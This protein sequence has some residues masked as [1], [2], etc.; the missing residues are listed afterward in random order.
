[1]NAGRTGAP[2]ANSLSAGRG[3]AAE[4][5]EVA[6]SSGRTAVPEAGGVELPVFRYHPDPLRTGSVEPSGAACAACGKTRGFLYCEPVLWES[7]PEG[8]VCPWCIASGKAHAKFGG[9]FIDP[10]AIGGFGRWD[11]VPPDVI[12]EIAYRTPGFSGW[13]E[14]RW[15]S[16]C[17]DAAEF[18]GPGGRAEVEALGPEASQALQAEAGLNDQ[19]WARRLSLLDRAHGPTAYLFRCR[20]CQRLGGY[21]DAPE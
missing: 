15:W 4:E 11:S 2:A 8:H 21:T 6:K 14:E 12:L 19:E 17:G 7:E 1:M 3:R 16:H 5:D 9:E 18:L 20:R 13:T 10:A